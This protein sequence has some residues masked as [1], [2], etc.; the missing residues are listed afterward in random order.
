MF[1][2]KSKFQIILYIFFLVIIIFFSKFSTNFAQGKNYT[3]SNIKIIETYDL[4][5]DK[6]TT[7]DKGFDKAFKNIISKLLQ[8]KDTK[9]FNKVNTNEIKGLIDNFSITDEKFINNQYQ[10]TFEVEFDRNKLIKFI[11]SKNVSPSI[12][13]DIQLLLVPLFIN[14]DKNELY[15]FEQNIFFE[16]WNREFK[17]EHLLK[18]NFPSEDIEDFQELKKNLRNIEDY[19]YDEI[20]KKYNFSNYIIVNFF[21][22]K[23][24]LKILSKIT[25][26]SQK[27]L[28]NEQIQNF[29][30]S[31]YEK[32]DEIIYKL[33]KIYEDSWKDINKINQSIAL[34]IKLKIESKNYKLTENF[35]K[36]LKSYELV[37]QFN[38][39]KF[40]NSE[41]LYKI[42]F[43]GMPSKFIEYMKSKNLVIEN[44]QEI[45]ILR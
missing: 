20:I 17:D 5:F 21:K 9:F 24:N 4:N 16:R 44:N 43:N 45:W 36:T 32:I 19:N 38:I 22:N 35:E 13:I 31:N 33:K 39:E 1:I 18:Y 12:P 7:I 23:N 27:I 8:E 29:N 3:I 41:I 26:G 34:P 10:S 25:F 14:L 6:Q 30:S 42:I 37:S 2:L 15:Y 11:Q 28:I 40:D